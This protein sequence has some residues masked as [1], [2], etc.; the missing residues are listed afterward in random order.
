MPDHS[1]LAVA[2][3]GVRRVAHVAA[4]PR[5]R[6]YGFHQVASVP[7]NPRIDSGMFIHFLKFHLLKKPEVSIILAIAR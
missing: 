4:V 7:A 6:D 1:R 5:G 3:L 2:A